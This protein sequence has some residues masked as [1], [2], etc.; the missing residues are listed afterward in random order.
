MLSKKQRIPKAIARDVFAR[1]NHLSSP[2]FL[3]KVALSSDASLGTRFAVSV[4]KKV[5]NTAVL[6]NRTRRRVYSSIRKLIPDVVAGYLVA[7]TVKKGGEKLEFA[8]I[9]KEITQNLIRAGVL[10]K[11]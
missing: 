7:I 11:K 9:E 10:K 4:S 3:L 5:A 6:R 8:D 1:A 2:H